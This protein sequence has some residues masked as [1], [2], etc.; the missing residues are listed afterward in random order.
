MQ[1]TYGSANH[2]HIK[3][4]QAKYPIHIKHGHAKW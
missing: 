2:I 1:H 4:G 3:H